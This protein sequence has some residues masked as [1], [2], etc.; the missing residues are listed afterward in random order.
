MIAEGHT[1]GP[2]GRPDDSAPS[3]RRPPTRRHPSWPKDL[4]SPYRRYPMDAPT[5]LDCFVRPTEVKILVACC[6]SKERKNDGPRES[7]CVFTTASQLSAAQSLP[8]GPGGRTRTRKRT[9]SNEQRALLHAADIAISRSALQ[10]RKGWD[11]SELALMCAAATRCPL[12]PQFSRPVVVPSWA[13][14]LAR[15]S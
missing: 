4:R 3:V 10:F 13:R 15:R 2:G 12:A 6:Q 1:N 7:I 11:L 14:G 9:G 8:T 5:F